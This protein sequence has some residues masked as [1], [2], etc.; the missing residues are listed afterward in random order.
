M[1]Y[2]Y[3]ARNS[4]V[5]DEESTVGHV[6][7]RSRADVDVTEEELRVAVQMRRAG[8]IDAKELCRGH[9]CVR[10]LGRGLKKAF[11]SSRQFSDEEGTRTLE[12]ILRVAYEWQHFVL[13]DLYRAMRRWEV[14]NGYTLFREAE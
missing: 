5:I 10:V 14:A 11:G 12:G 1:K 13:T 3:V 2:K 8:D 4:Y 6:Y 7:G 9:D